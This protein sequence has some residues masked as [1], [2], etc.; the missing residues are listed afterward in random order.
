MAASKV[1]YGLSNVHYCLIT[2]TT[3][4]GV[5]STTYGT[6]KAIPGAVNLSLSPSASKSVFRADN[7]DYYISYGQGGFEGDLEIARVPDD[8]KTDVL[9]YKEDDNKILVQDSASFSTVTYFAF[10][11]EF[12]GDARK[13]KFAFYKCS[14]S[15]PNIASQ[16]TGENGQIDPQTDTMTITSVPRADSDK[17][18]HCHT[19]ETSDADVVAAWYTNVYVPEFT[20]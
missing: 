18:I 14:A 20:P 8:F 12:E 16:T 15:H 19:Q 9:G 13:Q 4:N 3:T 11:F 6:V 7:S 2:E 5:T 10:L 17:L 1:K